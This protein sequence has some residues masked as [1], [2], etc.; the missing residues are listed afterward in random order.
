MRGQTAASGGPEI[1]STKVTA[2]VATSTFQKSVTG[3]GTLA[4][5]V[6]DSLSFGASGTVTAVD[7]AVGDTVAAGQVLAT[8]D[9]L[10]LDAA[11]AAAK[12]TLATAQAQLASAQ[13][14]DDG[15]DAADAQVASRQAAVD[16]AQASDDAAQAD[17][18][19]ATLTATHAGLV[20]AVNVTVGD[21]VGGGSSGGIGGNGANAAADTSTAAF[22]I[23]GTDAWEVTVNVGENDVADIAAGNQVE[24]TG[25]SLADTVFG[26]VTSV[27]LLPTT[28]SGAVSY[29]VTI[30]VTGTPEGL[31]DGV[32]VTATIIYERRSDVLAVPS[33]AVT[34]ADDGT[35]TVDVVGDDGATTPTT[36]TLGDRNGQ[37]VEVT[38]GLSAGQTVQYTQ[39][40]ISRAGGTG[41]RGQSGQGFQIPDGVRFPEGFTPPDGTGFPG[42]AVQGG[43]RG[44]GQ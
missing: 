44:G 35:T 22:E 13:A 37:D 10:Q 3:T 20:T 33:A 41:Q 31:H 27:A 23:V 7:V 12:A 32:S 30:A 26:T 36:V 4:P 6:Q 9:T 38:D 29:P 18:A 25:D 43:T 28:S 39:T 42:G 19:D 8:I 17:L 21:T 15:S 40:T 2:T 14:D 16:V 34:T 5:T 1:T 24:L 11:A